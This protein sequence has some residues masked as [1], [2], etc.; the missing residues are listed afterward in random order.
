MENTKEIIRTT[1]NRNT[2]NAITTE[3]KGNRQP[4]NATH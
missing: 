1:V 2:N 3:K 4:R